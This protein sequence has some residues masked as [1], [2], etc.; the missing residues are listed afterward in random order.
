[1]NIICLELVKLLNKY[2]CLFCNDSSIYY[3][4]LNGNSINE[5]EICKMWIWIF[6]GK[7]YFLIIS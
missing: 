7:L 3:C 6:E 1:M 2:F 5:F 4:F